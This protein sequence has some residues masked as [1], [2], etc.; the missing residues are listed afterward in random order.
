MDPSMVVL[1]FVNVT[2]SYG[3]VIALRNA[4]LSLPRGVLAGLLGPNGAGKTT[5]LKLAAGL[6]RRD[7]G[8]IQVLGADP[9]ANPVEVKSRIGLLHERPLY[10]SGVGVRELLRFLSKLRGYG[11]EEVLRVARLV[12]LEDYLD[13]RVNHLSRGYLQRLGLAQA[14]I[15]DPELLLLDEP[16]ANLDP[17]ARREILSLIST[18]KRDLGVTIVVSSHIVPELQE[19]CDYAVFISQGTVVAQGTLAELGRAF[20]VE[21][22]YRIESPRPRELA[23]KLVREDFVLGVEL[24]D[25][26]VT[27]RIRSGSSDDLLRFLENLAPRGLVAKVEHVSSDLG[28]LYAKTVGSSS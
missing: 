6:L 9:W 14:L 20:L 1:E 19:V 28:D 17:L 4:S 25:G 8:F 2:K 16:T 26:W 7:S 27:V 11:E 22:K 12:G 15:G 5:T 10:P 24:G 18:L 21:S 13:R 23:S 3:K